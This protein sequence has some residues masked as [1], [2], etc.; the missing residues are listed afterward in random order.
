[1]SQFSKVEN[2]WDAVKPELQARFTP[3]VFAMW[4]Q[5]MACLSQT[6]TEVVLSVPNEFSAIWVEDN[7]LELISDKVRFVAG[8]PIKV[9]LKVH[10]PAGLSAEQE[11]DL[12][13]SKKRDDSYRGGDLARDDI[14]RGELRTAVGNFLNPKNTFENFVVGQSNNLAHAAAVAVANAPAKAYN[15]LFVYGDTGL[16]KTHLMHAVGHFILKHNRLAKVAYV[17]T[18][19]FTNEF[20]RAIQENTL[21]KFRKRYRS[22]DVLLIDDIHFLSGKERIQEEFFH[23]FNDLF[24]SGKQIFLTSDR[25]ASEIAKLESRLVSRF[26]WGLVSDMQAPELETR[27]AILSNK[28]DS[29]G[30]Q[31]PEDVLQFIAQ[32]VSRN[33]RRLEGALTRVASYHALMGKSVNLEVAEQLLGDI[34]QEEAQNQ[35]TV[36]KIQKRVADYFNLR[37]SDMVSRRRPAN[38]AFPRQIAM[39]LSRI[40]TSHPLQ[41]IG[42]NFGGRDHGTVIHACKT[43]ENIMDQDESVRRSVEYLKSQLAKSSG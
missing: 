10:E 13:I 37:L 22:V 39:Y 36:E 28:A 32:K 40:L 43:V 7:Y 11:L 41:E 15:P 6:E 33:I 4:F 3:D 20:I 14:R 35:V 17:S 5:P 21:V 24:E 8:R 23:T 27:V 38:I 2:F 34:L 30:M 19:K 42:E 31:L 29:L 25:P 26:Q 18:E 16:G 12:G 1:M 9:S